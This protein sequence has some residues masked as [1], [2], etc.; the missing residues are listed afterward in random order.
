MLRMLQTLRSPKSLPVPFIALTALIVLIAQFTLACAKPAEKTE[1]AAPALA[2][3]A[4][5]PSECN[6][7]SPCAGSVCLGSISAAAAT[8]PADACP[9]FG[10]FQVDVDAFAWNSF[11]ALNWPAN[12]ASCSADTTQSISASGPRVWETYLRDSD[13]FVG[14]GSPATWCASATTL[15]LAG[16]RPFGRTGKLSAAQAA[17][18]PAIAEAVGGVLTDQ[19]GR[20]VRYEVLINQDEY[21]YLIAND[22]WQK[23]GQQGKT[24]N[25]PQGPNDNPS[26]C[27]AAPCGPVGAME[28][29]AAWKVLSAAEIAAGRFHTTQ[30]TVYNDENGSAS[31][32]PNPVTLGLVGLHILHKTESEATWF[33]STFEHV[34]NTSRSFFNPNCSSCP[35]NQQTAAQP[36][37]E[38]AANGTPINKGA[39]VVRTNSIAAND[40]SAPPL[41]TWYQG[42]LAGTVWANYQLVSTQWA[43]GGAPQGTPAVLANT[44]LETYIQPT[45]S[46]F[47]CHGLATTTAGTPADFSF[48][49]GGAR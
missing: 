2:A 32:G 43:T 9:R 29:K 25:F 44:T 16:A 41:N 7:S 37:T 5:V 13:V 40:S 26:R 19:N 30:G 4:S 15:R 42:L 21:N 22:L 49:L 12:L 6:P 27:G 45:S 48:L 33:W 3:K 28:I 24:I 31:P 14:A 1:V 36:F 20:F 11:V 34:D 39:Q 47:G 23:S 46:C 35:S 38:L 17:A 18:L 10:E 8:V